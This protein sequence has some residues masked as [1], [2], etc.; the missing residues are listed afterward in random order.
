V[1]LWQVRENFDAT[2]CAHSVKWQ[3]RS[4]NRE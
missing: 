1:R 3:K 4:R 2:T